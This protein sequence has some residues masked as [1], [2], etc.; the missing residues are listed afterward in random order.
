[1]T[2]F[3]APTGDDLAAIRDQFVANAAAQ[4]ISS[5]SE[6]TVNNRSISLSKIYA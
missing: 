5:D 3:K 1:M 2:R 6:N 4:S